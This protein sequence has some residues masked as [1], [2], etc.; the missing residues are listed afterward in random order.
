MAKIQAGTAIVITGIEEVDRKLGNFEV[1]VQRKALRKATREAAKVV[2]DEAKRL[3]P[4]ASGALKR[5]LRVRALKRSRVKQGHQ[6]QTGEGFF[7]GETFYGGFQEYGTKFMEANE[8]M[9]PAMVSKEQAVKEKF[10]VE[11]RAA[12]DEAGR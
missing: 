1:N 8:Y 10:R 2:L 6:V 12:V 4:V 3:A 9:R 5:S 7:K 11:M